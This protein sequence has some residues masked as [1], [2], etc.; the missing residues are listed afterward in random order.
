MTEEF[1]FY[2]KVSIFINYAYVYRLT[3]TYGTILTTIYHTH[4][5]TY[6]QI[7]IIPLLH[8]KTFSLTS[9]G[10]HFSSENVAAH[11]CHMQPDT[12][13]GFGSEDGI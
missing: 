2:F 5:S 1:K 4:K 9:Q 13:I 6:L 11:R 3:G 12:L 8:K 10:D 7:F